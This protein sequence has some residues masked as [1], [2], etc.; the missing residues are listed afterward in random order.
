MKKSS[1]LSKH[2]P[3]IALVLLSPMLISVLSCNGKKESGAKVEVKKIT[4][5][6]RQDYIPYAYVD[7]SGKLTGY[8]YDILRAAEKF[9]PQYKFEYF[10]TGQEDALLGLETGRNQIVVSGLFSNPTRVAKYGIPKNPESATVTGFYVNA[11]YK[12]K[13]QGWNKEDGYSD[14]FYNNLKVAPIFG[15][16]GILGIAEE[17]NR[18][19]PDRKISYETGSTRIPNTE[20]FAWVLEGRYDA[21]LGNESSFWQTYNLDG[22]SNSSGTPDPNYK[23]KLIFVP[24]YS[25]GVW[26]FFNKNETQLIEDYNKAFEELY[27]NG[28]V[29][30]L[31]EKYFGKEV[32]SGLREHEKIRF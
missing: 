26:P 1:L 30:T 3:K 11:K 9:L 28:T 16:G 19:N 15:A 5:A 6:V 29:K 21:V 8:E 14:I 2:L 10:A 20:F 7:E 24:T 17:Y 18:K 31:Q 25:I 32:L 13:L 27:K 22:K 23:D 4:V 12:D